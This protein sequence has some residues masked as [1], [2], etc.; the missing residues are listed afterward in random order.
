MDNPDLNVKQ[1]GYESKLGRGGPTADTV[2]D[3]EG[4]DMGDTEGLEMHQEGAAHLRVLTTTTHAH[5]GEE[6][7]DAVGDDSELN[8]QRRSAPTTGGSSQTSEI[9]NDDPVNDS[10]LV[11][12]TSISSGK[13][14]EGTQSSVDGVSSNDRQEGHRRHEGLP[15]DT[16]EFMKDAG[17]TKDTPSTM[18]TVSA[19]DQHFTSKAQPREFSSPTSATQDATN[20]ISYDDEEEERSRAEPTK[21]GEV[22]STVTGQQPRQMTQSSVDAREV[23]S[24]LNAQLNR[25]WGGSPPARAAGLVAVREIFGCRQELDGLLCTLAAREVGLSSM[26]ASVVCG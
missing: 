12:S 6:T 20:D 21:Y 18:D 8:R 4:R 14:H 24:D 23:E 17:S 2:E 5:G 7:P 3:R 15:G 1:G 26:R 10:P 11:A 25:L 16:A 19:D 22:E 9:L 13:S